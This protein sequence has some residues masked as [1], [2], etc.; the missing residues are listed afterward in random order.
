MTKILEYVEIDV[1]SCSLTY[2]N[3]PCTASLGV[4]GTKKCFNSLNTCQDRPN[5]NNVPVTL[6]FAT[7]TGYNP[8]DIE[9][10]PS[11]TG[12]SISPSEI[13]LGGDLGIRSSVTIMFKD[14]RHSDAGPGFDKYLADRSYDPY[15]QGTFWARFRQRQLFLRGRPLRLIRGELGDVLG[16]METRN[17]VVDSFTGPSSSGTFKIVAKDVLKLADNDRAVAPAPSGGALNGAITNVATSATLSPSGIGNLD[18]AASGLVAIGGKEICAYTRSGDVLTLTRGQR[19]T[20]AQAHTA[21]SRVQAVLEYS[22]LSPDVILRDLFVTYAGVPSSYISVATWDA[23]VD[24]FLQRVYTATIAEPTG[25]NKLASELIEQAALALWWDDVGQ[26]LKLQVLRDVPKQATTYDDDTMVAGS[27]TIED[28]PNKRFSQAW[29]YFAQR[30]PLR[31]LTDLDNYKSI[32]VNVNTQNEVD[33][34]SASIKPITS[35]WI[36]EFGSSIA[37]RLSD[38]ILARFSNAPR[39][40]TFDLFK[41]DGLTLPELGGAHNIGHTFL[42]TDEGAADTVPVQ[43]V[44]L[45]PGKT[46]VRVTT[47]ELRFDGITLDDTNA[48]VITIDSNTNNF[49]LR[50]IHDTLFSVI[51]DATDITLTVNVAAGV[52]VGSAS[53]S[54]VA[55]DV[56][57]WIDLPAITINN[58][59]TIAGAGGQGVNLSPTVNAEAGGTALLTAV[60][61]TV[62]NSGVIQGGGGG[63]SGHT[64]GTEQMAGGGGAGTAIGPVGTGSGG[65]LA[66][67]GVAA[68][69]TVGGIVFRNVDGTTFAGRGGGPGLAGNAATGGVGVV[70]AVGAAGNAVDGVSNITFSIA[71]TRTGPEIN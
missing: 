50:T 32:Y 41:A 57:S 54:S 56:G 59:G 3:A 61:I 68:T 71:G 47:E 37:A 58:L 38:I 7:D 36:P 67:T 14:H 34:G 63:A 4:T 60:A 70:G 23:E 16:S 42:Q 44:S 62:A 46:A 8:D 17:Y 49:N 40:I 15:T 35:R 55:F 20:E 45:Q 6:R 13:S 53:R 29:V 43:V 19:N 10:I 5:F 33:F 48:R 26:Q 18:Y 31:P 2:S 69:A 65:S 9:A 11:I 1:D 39:R 30:N 28:Q 21:S 24:A 25:V 27:P 51:T 22:G 12:I 52:V 66:I 64:N